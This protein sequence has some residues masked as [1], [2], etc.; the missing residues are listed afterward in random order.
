MT[1][2]QIRTQIQARQ[3]KY[4]KELLIYR[5]RRQAEQVYNHWARAVGDRPS[6]IPSS[7]S[8]PLPASSYL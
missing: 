3:R 6:P 1:L 7:G 2:R 8:S 5:L 4:A